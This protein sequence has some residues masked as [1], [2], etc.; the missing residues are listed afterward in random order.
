MNTNEDESVTNA[1][2]SDVT[3]TLLNYSKA[4]SCLL[5]QS[6]FNKKNDVNFGS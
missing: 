3:S 1:N 4:L 2:L 5:R 6:L